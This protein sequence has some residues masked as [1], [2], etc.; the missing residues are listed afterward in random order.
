MVFPSFSSERTFQINLQADYISWS[1]DLSIVIG[2]GKVSLEYKD[3]QIETENVRIDL[4]TSELLA[5]DKVN[6]RLKTR[7]IEGENLR[8]NLEKEEGTIHHPW[9]FFLY[10]GNSLS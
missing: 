10:V 8:Y 5:W 1:E 6:F 4:H 7:R 9:T 3:V 2:K